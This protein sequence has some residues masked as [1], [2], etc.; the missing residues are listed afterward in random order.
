MKNYNSDYMKKYL[1]SKNFGKKYDKIIS[2]KFEILIWNV[3][4]KILKKIYKKYL[5]NPKINYLDFACGT[6]RI[7]TYFVNELGIKNAYGMDTS[8]P[9]LNEAKKKTIA[10]FIN[11]NIVKEEKLLIDKKFSLITS[12]RLFLN[13][14][15]KNRDIILK[16]LH[17][18]LDDKNGYLIINNHLNRYSF[19]GIF[20]WIRH[21][22]GEKINRKNNQGILNT[23]S[24]REFRKLIKKNGFKIVKTY[25]F[26]LFPGRKNFIV[27]PEKILINIEIFLSKIPILNL[28]CKDQIFLCKKK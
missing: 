3:E 5:N 17:K 27:L 12:F 10:K 20:F 23:M 15:E 16:K 1:S 2:N 28:F 26:V 22:L 19:L 4:K 9:M 18:N 6:G 13:L 14:E 11:K 8:K 21:L 7:I 24:E 25:R